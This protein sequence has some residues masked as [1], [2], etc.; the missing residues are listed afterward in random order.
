M[1]APLW[2]LIS[3]IQRGRSGIRTGIPRQSLLANNIKN[4]QKDKINDKI[5]IA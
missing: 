2:K 3:S 1:N 4:F 5:Y